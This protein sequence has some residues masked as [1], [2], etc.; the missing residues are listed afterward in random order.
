V[1]QKCCKCTTPLQLVS[2]KGRRVLLATL[3]K[4]D[5][6][7]QRNEKAYPGRKGRIFEQ[8]DTKEIER[9]DLS[10]NCAD[11]LKVKQLIAAFE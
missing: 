2:S 3:G 8:P 4:V 7:V 6:H 9:A 1:S 11:A 10:M 5:T